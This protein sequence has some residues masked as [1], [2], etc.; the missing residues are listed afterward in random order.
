MKSKRI[1]I[2]MVLL[3]AT[4]VSLAYL[5]K[6][7]SF[8]TDQ[9]N[10]MSSVVAQ[11]NINVLKKFGFIFKYAEKNEELFILGTAPLG[12]RVYLLEEKAPKV[13]IAETIKHR[14]DSW[15]GD[16]IYLT[17]LKSIEDC[18]PAKLYSLAIIGVPVVSYQ[19]IT[20]Q[21]LSDAKF[22]ADINA[23]IKNSA[24]LDILKTNAQGNSPGDKYFPIADIMPDVYML[25]VLD[26]EIFVAS[27]E[28][29]RDNYR[30]HGPRAI[31]I[32]GKIHP[33]TGWCSWPDFRVFAVNGSYYL[34]SGSGCCGC[35]ITVQE[36][37]EIKPDGVITVHDDMSYSD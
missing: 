4:F 19:T 29:Q 15:A 7:V 10:S 26:K 24:A 20:Y 34:E 3:M 30:M 31:V 28:V 9:V 23:K 2:V 8:S 25:H 5:F 35:G 37:F 21:K 12:E 16:S 14:E 11:K 33:L 17:S 1:L 18:G 27:Y 36:L 22:I 6:E 32:D 13:C